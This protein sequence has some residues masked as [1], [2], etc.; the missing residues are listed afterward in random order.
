MASLTQLIDGIYLAIEA[1][2][3]H[4]CAR[5]LDLKSDILTRA[6]VA[7]T[8]GSGNFFRLVAIWRQF[9]MERFRELK[10]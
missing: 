4:K 2:P 6:K 10:S 9:K 3:E 8:F 1:E 5:N 7:Q